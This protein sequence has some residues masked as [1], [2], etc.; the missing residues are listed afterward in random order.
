MKKTSSEND[1]FQVRYEALDGKLVIKRFK[2]GYEAAT[3]YYSV[4]CEGVKDVRVVAV[5]EIVERNMLGQ[6]EVNGY[7]Y[8]QQPP[9]ERYPNVRTMAA[10]A[11]GYTVSQPLPP[12]L[13]PPIAPSMEV[14]V[15][16]S[17][18]SAHGTATAGQR[19]R[20]RKTA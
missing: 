5:H 17:S 13:R 15:P 2:T 12:P 8:A 6:D 19:G 4:Q 18:A 10:G 16:T 1:F 7:L 14:E 3:A 20:P 11:G 9:Q